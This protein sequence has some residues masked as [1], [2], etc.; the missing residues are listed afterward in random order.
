MLK[1]LEDGPQLPP[2]DDGDDRGLGRR[3]GRRVGRLLRLVF[4]LSIKIY[5]IASSILGYSALGVMTAWTFWYMRRRI[6]Q[7]AIAAMAA[8]QAAAESSNLSQP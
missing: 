4:T 8:Q 7:L 3:A 1:S 6:T 2:R 5:M